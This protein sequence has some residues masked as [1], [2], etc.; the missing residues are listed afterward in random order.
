M[1]TTTTVLF[2]VLLLLPNL[3]LAI[4]TPPVTVDALG[5]AIFRVKTG[6]RGDI[7]W[8]ECGS[9][10]RGD[11]ARLRAWQYASLL[12]SAHQEYPEFDPW[13]GAAIIFQ[14]SSFDRCAISSEQWRQFQE[15]YQDRYDRDPGERDIARLLR[16]HTYRRSLGIPA[17]DAGLA[18]FRWPGAAAR[19]AGVEDPADLLDP[20]TSIS[21]LARAL[22]SHYSSCEEDYSGTYT[23][24]LRDGRVRVIRYRVSCDDGYWVQHNS[25]A[26]FN[27]RYYSNIVHKRDA[28][29]AA[30]EEISRNDSISGSREA[31]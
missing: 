29:I 21:M 4:D 11:E 2:A 7:R 17:F 1:K 25:P 26:R 6:E 30:Y 18:Q 27:Y 8:P 15:A 16:N 14:E 24:P 31:S 23:R 13:V 22:T 9:Y 10:I 20:E 19:N 12:V 28:L 3:A 5:S